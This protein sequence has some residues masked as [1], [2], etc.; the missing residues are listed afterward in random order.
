M[1]LEKIKDIKAFVLDVDGVL[2]NGMLM[3]TESGE[4]LRQFNLK[5]GYALQLAVKRGFKI[6]ILSEFRSKSSEHHFKNLGT[7]DIY[8]GLDSKIEAY[9]D[10]INKHSLSSEHV[11][12]MG[13][14]IPDL[15][16]M[17]L[18]GLAVCPVDAVE[19]IKSVAD[20]I[21]ARKGGEALVR[22]IIE[23]VLKL[24]NLWFDKSLSTN[25]GQ[26]E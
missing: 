20:Y 5:D 9:Q 19:E 7:I 18:A 1:F 16:L 2:T 23:K 21:S 6:A 3:L 24:Q 25:D 8:L 26:L 14:D 15:E 4:Q 13:D 10:F 17:K 11:L 12:F 22:D